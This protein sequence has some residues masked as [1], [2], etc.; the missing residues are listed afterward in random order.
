[1]QCPGLNGASVG[2]EGLITVAVTV[3][4]FA[5]LLQRIVETPSASVAVMGEV[6]W[7]SLQTQL[8]T[9]L[10]DSVALPSIEVW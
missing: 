9:K 1:M 7:S 2:Q 8:V 4:P 3:G 10:G 5:Y 6:A